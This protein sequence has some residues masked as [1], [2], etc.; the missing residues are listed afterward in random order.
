MRSYI[1][2][3]L[4]IFLTGF[5]SRAMSQDKA[6]IIKDIRQEYQRINSISSF[7]IVKLD[8]EDFAE[9]T[10]DGGA[11]LKAYYKKDSLLKITEWI[12][13]SF[14]NRSREYYFK[15]N[16]LFFVFEKFD[17][18]VETKD[19]LDHTKTKNSF[20]GRYYY[21][22]NKL[23]QTTISGKKPMDDQPVSGILTDAENNSKLLN[24]KR[25]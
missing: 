18:F 23:I 11:E 13:L 5:Y 25:K 6:D 16:Q 2:A 20:Q 19:G 1:R 21:S 24:N 15:N 7:H 10:P 4:L 14:G 17:S 22:N 12:G 9:E 8:A 3:A